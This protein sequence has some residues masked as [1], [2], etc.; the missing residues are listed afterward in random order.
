[1]NLVDEVP[2]EVVLVVLT[3]VRHGDQSHRL[4]RE[5]QV[6]VEQPRVEHVEVTI[7]EIQSEGLKLV[8]MGDRII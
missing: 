7:T 3:L 4:V 6:R 2:A 1:M 8:K 5:D